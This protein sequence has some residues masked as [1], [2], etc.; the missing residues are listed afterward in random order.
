MPTGSRGHHPNIAAIYGLEQSGATPA[1]VMELVD[2][3]TLA[4]R[5]TQGAIP[6][7]EALPMA[8]QIA[9]ADDRKH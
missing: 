2:G 6:L 7:D 5:L 3:P 8:M 9:D 1:L 4:D